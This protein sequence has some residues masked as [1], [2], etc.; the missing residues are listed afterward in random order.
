MNLLA[1]NSLHQKAEH[2]PLRNCSVAS[3]HSPT[4]NLLIVMSLL[5]FMR[6]KRIVYDSFISK[7]LRSLPPVACRDARQG[8]GPCLQ[9]SFNRAS[10]SNTS[11]STHLSYALV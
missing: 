11:A 10:D 5:W 9:R 8:C 6:T 3:S 7:K 1:A 2:G 4:S